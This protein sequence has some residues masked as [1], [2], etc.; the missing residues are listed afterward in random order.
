MHIGPPSHE[1]DGVA[2]LV[3]LLLRGLAC[4]SI[5]AS[6][7]GNDKFVVRARDLGRRSLPLSVSTLFGGVN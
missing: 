4:E 7:L 3:G 1:L 5:A 2:N 6:T